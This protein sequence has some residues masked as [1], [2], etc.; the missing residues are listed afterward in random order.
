MQR[1]CFW[2]TGRPGSG[3]SVLA[4]S[5]IQTA[6]ESDLDSAFYFFRFGDQ[7]KNN[8]NIL[9]LSLAYQIASA[10]PAYRRRLLRLFGDGLNVQNSAP[11]LLWQK[12]FVSTFLKLGLARPLLIIIDGLDECDSAR[13]FLKFLEDLHA[14]PGSVRVLLLSRS[15][16]SLSLGF[17]RLSKRLPVRH[18]TLENTKEDLRM[19]VEEEMATMHGDED[20]KYAIAAELV[21]KADGYFLW[22]SLVLTEVLGCHTKDAVLKALEEVPEELEPLYERMDSTLAK[23]CRPSDRAMGK[24]ILMWIACSRHPLDLVNLAEALQPE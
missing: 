18:H 11:R 23:M 4:S 24:T 3:K 15:T 12:L 8:L 10:I 13:I 7:V 14:F 19:Y 16:Q 20:F 2:Y 6:Q 17:E 1:R 22:A 9:L 21:R 5:I